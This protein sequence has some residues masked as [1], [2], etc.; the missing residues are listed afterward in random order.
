MELVNF[1]QCVG[2]D[3]V[4]C[5]GVTDNFIRQAKEVHGDRYDYSLTKISC[6]DVKIP[7]SALETMRNGNE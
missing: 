6:S 4:H 1:P 3:C 5:K 2:D 7:K